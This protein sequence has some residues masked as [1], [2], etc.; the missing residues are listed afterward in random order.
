MFCTYSG[1][2]I[3]LESVILTLQ[4]DSTWN[5]YSSL[6]I[7][8]STVDI[9]SML[10]NNTCNRAAL[11]ANFLTSFGLPNPGFPCFNYS[12][13]A[14]LYNPIPI[15]VPFKGATSNPEYEFTNKASMTNVQEDDISED[16]NMPILSISTGFYSNYSLVDINILYQPGIETSINLTLPLPVAIRSSLKLCVQKFNTTV[17]DSNTTTEQVSSKSFDLSDTEYTNFTFFENG[18]TFGWDTL[19]LSYFKGFFI[20]NIPDWCSFIVFSADSFSYLTSCHSTAASTIFKKFNTTKDPVSAV[21]S[22]MEN[23]AISLTNRFVIHFSCCIYYT[24]FL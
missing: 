19:T 24:Y 11:D 1:S 3:F 22:V 15:F 12:L 6:G 17:F 14:S 20:D 13:P 5:T 23:V 21:N 18:T 8:A 9:S 10:I 16:V 2:K 4:Y 7:C